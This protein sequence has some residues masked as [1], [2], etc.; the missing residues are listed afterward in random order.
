MRATLKRPKKKKKERK[1]KKYGA[2]SP[3]EFWNFINNLKE[4]KWNKYLVV[5]FLILQ[6]TD[7]TNSYMD[8][9]TY[10]KDIK[11]K[12]W[13]YIYNFLKVYA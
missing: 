9:F 2:N 10:E 1:K 7:N 4:S 5:E 3:R 6:K 13:T 8:T 11:E 12:F